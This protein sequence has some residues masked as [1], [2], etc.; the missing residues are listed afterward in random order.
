MTVVMAV[1]WGCRHSGLTVDTAE[2]KLY[3]QKAA[4]TKEQ[5]MCIIMLDGWMERWMIF[6]STM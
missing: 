5:R 4:Q 6:V 1:R 3:L 2:Y